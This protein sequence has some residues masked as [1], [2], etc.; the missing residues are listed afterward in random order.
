VLLKDKE[1]YALLIISY[2]DQ[3]DNNREMAIDLIK[4]DIKNFEDLESYELC[5]RLLKTLKYFE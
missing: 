2:M 4:S 1:I 3:C 5:D